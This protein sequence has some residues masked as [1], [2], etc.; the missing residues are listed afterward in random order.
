MIV[1]LPA[2]HSTSSRK[3]LSPT[4]AATLTQTIASTLSTVLALPPENRSTPSTR[5][6]LATSQGDEQVIQKPTLLLAE[7]LAQY[8]PGM[9]KSAWCVQTRS[10]VGKE[11]ATGEG[12]GLCGSW[13]RG[14]TVTRN[15][16][17]V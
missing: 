8:P 16:I 11:A 4:Q 14:C 17:S 7:K 2:Y 15:G 13:V 10:G 1:N 9:L 3:S 5:H 6:F 12:R